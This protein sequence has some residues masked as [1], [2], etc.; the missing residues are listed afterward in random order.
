M[1]S[2]VDKHR[3]AAGD[4]EY[5]I[6]EPADPKPQSAPLIVFLHG[7]SATNPATYGAWLDHLVKRGNIVVY[8][9]YQADL[10]TPTRT[11]TSNAAGAIRAAIKTLQSEPNHVRPD[12][13]HFAVVGHSVGGLLAANMAAVARAE[14]L[15]AVRAV[16]AVEPARTW[17]PIAATNVELKNLAMIPADT[18]LIALSGDRDELARDTDAKRVYNES[19]KVAP[20]NKNYIVLVTDN[21]GQPPLE[22]W[23]G[24]PAGANTAYD[25]G[26]RREG[27]R[28]GPIAEAVR[29]RIQERMRGA[30]GDA[31]LP[32]VPDPNSVEA[33]VN[34]MDFYGLWKL[35]DGLCDAAF[36]GKNR[37]F[38]L[39]DTKEQRF[40]GLWSDG[41]PVKE[42]RVIA[43]PK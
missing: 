37:K 20:Q 43:N 39:G 28:S 21:H 14:N 6:Y 32:Q 2:G 35:F 27:N 42:L 13:D 38:A 5:W 22:A 17:N 11:F 15:P 7:W 4:E 36:F 31:G 12:L 1:H 3:Y 33:G 23:H 19:T 34:A 26:E 10:R 8:P 9:R 25:N 16:M 29:E 40:M 41:S 18:L 30:E 24:A